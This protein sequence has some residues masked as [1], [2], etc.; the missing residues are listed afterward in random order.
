M[1]THVSPREPRTAFG[2]P[3]SSCDSRPPAREVEDPVRPAREIGEVRGWPCRPGRNLTASNRWRQI[4]SE[5]RHCTNR[6]I[7]PGYLRRYVPPSRP[8]YRSN[9]FAQVR[10]Y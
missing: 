9:L 1:S 7:V 3:R 2:A 8:T 6:P 10:R 5:A 4:V